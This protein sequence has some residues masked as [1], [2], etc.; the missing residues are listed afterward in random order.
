MDGTYSYKTVQASPDTLFIDLAGAKAEGVARSQQWANPVFSG[1]KLLAYQDAS[2]QPVV[3]VQVDTKHGPAFRR[4]E[5]RIN[6]AVGL[7][8]GQFVSAAA[9]P[10]PVARLRAS[11]RAPRG[12]LLRPPV[13]LSL[14][15]K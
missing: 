1:Y 11:R 2:G 13:G 12:I 15:R 10:A 5:G 3:R 4:P 8:K 7:G 9:V 6:A 14:F